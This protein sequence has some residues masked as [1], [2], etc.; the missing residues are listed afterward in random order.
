MRLLTD[1]S[2]YKEIEREY[3]NL[4]GYCDPRTE[5]AYEVKEIIE[6]IP[7]IELDDVLKTLRSEMS[8]MY[9]QSLNSLHP[10]LYV[11]YEKGIKFAIN[12]IKQAII[13]LEG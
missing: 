8:Y 9:K 3:G 5:V 7:G 12:I 2:I 4:D 11:G 1:E 10:D 13:K 6:S